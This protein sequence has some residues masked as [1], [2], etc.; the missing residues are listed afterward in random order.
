M[1]ATSV[2]VNSTGG[3]RMAAN[4]Y[5]E[6]GVTVLDEKTINGEQYL[7]Y[8]AAGSSSGALLTTANDHQLQLMA[9]ASLNLYVRRILVYQ[10]VLATTAA[11]GLFAVVRLSTAGT[12]GTA[13]TPV[14]LDTTDSA[15]GATAMAMPTAKGTEGNRVWIGSAGL[16]QTAPT[17]GASTLLFDINFDQLR[18]KA[19]RVPA[20]TANGIAFKNLAAFPAASVYVNMWFT[21]ASF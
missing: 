2:Q 11:I 9:G 10:V 12:G 6:G 13:L 16:M 1:T 20:G 8:Y 18:G 7:P 14:A 21:E 3:T 15:S 19:L 17:A 4:S 5:T